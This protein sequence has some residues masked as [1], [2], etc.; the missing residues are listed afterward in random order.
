MKKEL[1]GEVNGREVYLY[2]LENSHGMKVTVSSFV[3]LMIS[4]WAADNHGK[5]ADVAL[6]YDR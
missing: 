5:F 1:F 6:G 2:T 4:L 3:A